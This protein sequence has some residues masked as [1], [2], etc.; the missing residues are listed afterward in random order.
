VLAP[1]LHTL[2]TAD[3]QA[4]ALQA[5]LQQMQVLQKQALLLQQQPAMAYTDALK[6]LTLATQQTLGASGEMAVNAQRATV[7]LKSASADSLARWLSQARLNARC[8]PLEA[9]LTLVPSAQ[10]TQWSGVLVMGL[11]QQR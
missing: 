3:A 4:Q 11:P 6:A 1:A 10:G 2:R 7:T 5:Q 8:V 9:R